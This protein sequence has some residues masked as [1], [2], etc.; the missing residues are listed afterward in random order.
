MQDDALTFRQRLGLRLAGAAFR[1]RLR[2]LLS[3][4]GSSYGATT[5]VG[6]RRGGTKL[7]DAYAQHPVVYSCVKLLGDNVSQVPFKLYQSTNE[8]ERA[9]EARARYLRERFYR[10]PD[11]ELY[12]RDLGRAEGFEEVTSGDLRQLFDRPNPLMSGNQFWNATTVILSYLGEV[13]I[14]CDDRD[15]PTKVP[16]ELYPDKPVYYS[17][18][19]DKQLIPA[20]WEYRA[21]GCAPDMLDTWELIRPRT[22]NPNDP[23]R[24]LNPLSVL[25][26]TLAND[27]NARLYNNSYFENDATP[28]GFMFT[29]RPMKEKQR[30][31]WLKGYYK[32]HKGSENAFK[33]ALL[34]GIKNVMPLTG[35]PKD[36]QF[37][38]LNSMSKE[39]IAMVWRVPLVFLSRTS[40]INYATDKAERRGFWT[41]TLIPIIR[42]LE[43]IFWAELFRYIEGGRVWGVFDL[44][45]VED[46][47]EGLDSQLDRANKLYKMK[48]PFNRINDRL[49][50]GFDPETIPGGDTWI[51]TL[52]SVP[53]E[54]AVEGATI[55]APTPTQSEEPRALPEGE[56]DK[57]RAKRIAKVVKDFTKLRAPLIK[58]FTKRYRAYLR[59]YRKEVLDNLDKYYR[60]ADWDDIYLSTKATWDRTLERSVEGV[61]LEAID[62]SATFTAN[63]LGG[64]PFIMATSPEGIKILESRRIPLVGTNETLRD[65]L[66]RE[67]AEAMGK[68]ETVNQ[69]KKRVK[70]VM[71]IQ[72]SRAL[73]IARTEVGAAT[74]GARFGEMKAQGVLYTSW[75]TVGLGATPPRESHIAAQAVGPKPLGETFAGTRCRYP[76]DPEGPAGEVINCRCVSIPETT[77]K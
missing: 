77:T 25:A 46:L 51:V 62:G 23:R 7:I 35:S 40:D 31:T 68:G 75:S 69:V 22:Y 12:V 27:W 17:P 38:D 65:N 76:H 59:K 57:Q 44:N 70:K 74:S 55:P 64:T 63:E 53:I 28:G 4:G 72:D 37:V 54:Y 34:D 71:N 66:R 29:E 9:D 49:N 73:T 2:G 52:N 47:Q 60:L 33:W 39:E 21:P 45:E 50:L 14:K 41:T 15:D 26:L 61:Y 20:Y 16:T 32:Q 19:P 43:D 30:E 24:G 6:G 3:G 56:T 8:D 67:I 18:K 36:A 10:S 1:D 5:I 42:H 58:E 13:D 48:I 11:G